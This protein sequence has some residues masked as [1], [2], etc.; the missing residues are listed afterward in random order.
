MKPA[1]K[2]W[3]FIIIPVLIVVAIGL[4]VLKLTGVIANR[5]TDVQKLY[6]GYQSALALPGPHFAEGSEYQEI[7]LDPIF[8]KAAL[9]ESPLVTKDEKLAVI[10][11]WA[12]ELYPY[13]GSFMMA[14]AMDWLTFETGTGILKNSTGTE[15]TANSIKLWSENRIQHTQHFGFFQSFPGKDPWGALN[16]LEPVYKK[17]LPS[18]MNALSSYTGKVT[19]KC[20]SIAALHMG[21]FAVAG[22]DPDNII[23]LRY[24]SHDIGI[25]NYAGLLYISFNEQVNLIDDTIK[26]FILSQKYQGFF[27]YSLSIMQD[28]T[29]DDSFFAADSSLLDSITRL[30]RT[31]DKIPKAKL[32]TA[33]VMQ[34]R[35]KLKEKVFGNIQDEEHN[36]LF[37]LARYAYQSLYVKEPSL[38]LE[39]SIRAPVVIEL[40]KKLKAEDD[41]V[42]WIKTNIALEPIFDDYA[43]R[44]MIADQVVVLKKGGPKDQAVLA[45]ALLQINGM[46]PVIKITERTAYLETNGKLYDARSWE[47]V[48]QVEGRVMLELRA[49]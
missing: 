14:S 48:Q 23:I 39:A 6:S 29:L 41:I 49:E 36:K 22:A 38:Y 4:L 45:Y 30:T 1:L 17:V 10:N 35:E 2:K 15:K 16:S 9:N 18:E 3:I 26:E 27:N 42:S 46:E 12:T 21:L 11:K 20:C 47:T 44:I 31:A 13:F 37:T 19:G 7:D 24:G 8:Q 33:D 28:F 40:A 5:T 43:Q 25:V 34:D 32:L